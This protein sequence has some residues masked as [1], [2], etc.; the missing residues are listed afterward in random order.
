VLY[1]T[2]RFPTTRTS[3][4]LAD[5]NGRFHDVPVSEIKPLGKDYPAYTADGGVAC[6]VVEAKVREDW[7][8]H[9]YAPRILYWLDQHAFY[10]LRIEEYDQEGKLIYIE[11][12]VAEMRNP[13]LKEQGYGMVLDLYWDVPTDLMTYSVHDGHQ[14]RQWTD[15][16]RKA[17]FNPDF[18][19]RVWFIDSIKSQSDISRPEEFFLRPA[20]LEDSSCSVKN[21]RSGERAGGHEDPIHH[22]LRFNRAQKKEGTHSGFFSVNND[23][24]RE[25]SLAIPLRYASVSRKRRRVCYGIAACRNSGARYRQHVGWTLRGHHAGRYGCGCDQD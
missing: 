17:Y 24:L 7:L 3:I 2:V 1:Q 21:R 8:P 4:T 23:A 22:K 9:Y 20:L 18:M 14:L 13:A 10:P 25:T 15:E 5:A 6:Y 12:R 16:D 19:R 11:T